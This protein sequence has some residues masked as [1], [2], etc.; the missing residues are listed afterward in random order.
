MRG[1]KDTDGLYVGMRT[2]FEASSARA[3]GYRSEGYFRAEQAVVLELLPPT[4]RTVVDLCCGSGL[5]L[6]PL[7]TG[8]RTVFGID[9]NAR[10]CEGARANGFTVARGDAMQLPLADGS[11][12]AL[13]NCQF[14]NQQDRERVLRCLA[15]IA[16]VLRPGGQAVLVWRNGSAWIHIVAHAVLS[17]LDRLRGHEV[18]PQHVH[19]LEEVARAA[20]ELGLETAHREVTNPLLGWRSKQLASW[21]ARVMGASCVLVLTK[22]TP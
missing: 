18:F 13:V 15:E 21:P 6:L 19:R 14:F 4:A 16:R 5:M 9:F 12:D 7:K 17:V 11:V 20:Q 10:A 3:N 8:S 22:P 1:D 2:R